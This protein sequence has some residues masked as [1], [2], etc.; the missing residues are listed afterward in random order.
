M[1][2]QHAQLRRVMTNIADVVR[3]F[4]RSRTGCTFTAADLVAYV[5]A[6]MPAVAPDSPGRILR[7]LRRSGDV[8]VEL[9][10]RAGSR[11]RVRGKK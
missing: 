2:A 9:V 8:D 6:R 5:V 3:A 11:Y 10:D 7:E 1:T 4:C